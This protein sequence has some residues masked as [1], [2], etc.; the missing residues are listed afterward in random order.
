MG[1]MIGADPEV[2]Y[3]ASR[4]PTGTGDGRIGTAE[5]NAAIVDRIGRTASV[6]A[7]T[8]VGTRTP[9]TNGAQAAR[10]VLSGGVHGLRSLAHL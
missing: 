10:E 5:D 6:V 1:Q 2:A 4:Q 9:L 7:D 3:R 8:A